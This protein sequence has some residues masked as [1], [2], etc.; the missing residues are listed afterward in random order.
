[1]TGSAVVLMLIVCS[2][3]WGGFTVLLGRAVRSEGRKKISD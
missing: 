2:F 1:M 3:V